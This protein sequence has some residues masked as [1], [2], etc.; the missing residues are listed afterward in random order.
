[1]SPEFI[2]Q[3][4]RL[5]EPFPPLSS[6]EASLIRIQWLEELAVRPQC[7]IILMMLALLLLLVWLLV[8]KFAS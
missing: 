2:I 4:V 5:I 7:F 3:E 1:L 6:L 8:V